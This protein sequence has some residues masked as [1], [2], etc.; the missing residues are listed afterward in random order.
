MH[1]PLSRIAALGALFALVTLAACGGNSGPAPAMFTLGGSVRGLSASG[2]VLANGSATA[3]VASGASTFSF[4]TVLTQ[5]MS[6]AVTVQT[7]PIGQVCSI[8]NGSGTTGTADVANVVVTCANQAY[9]LGGSVSGLSGSGLV[10]ANGADTLAVPA[11]ATTFTMPTQVATGSSYSITVQTQPAG[12]SCTVTGGTGTMAAAAASTVA[13]SC[14]DQP[15]TLG[16]TISGLST[17]GLVIAN[18]DDSV[19]PAANAT[20]FTLPTPVDYGSAYALSVEIQPTG[21]MCTFGSGNNVAASSGTMPAANVTNTQLVCSLQSYPLGG[22]VT[23][24]TGS[25]VLTD[26]TDTVTVD[27]SS[28]LIFTMPTALAYGSAYAL[29]VQTQPIGLTCTPGSNSSGTMPASAVSV[30]VTCAANTYTLGGTI[31]GLTST[32]LVLANGAGNTVSPASG[33]TLFSLPNGVA[34]GSTYD[35]TASTQPSGQTCAV[36]SASGT[37]PASSV[38]SVQVSCSNNTFTTAGAY[39][40]TVPAGVTSIQVSAIGG[41]GGGGGGCCSSTPTV[42]GSGALVSSTLAVQPGDVLTIYVGGGG[43]ATNEGSGGGGLTYVGD[44]PTNFV[45][46][47][48]GGGAGAGPGNDA[49]GG[50]AGAAGAS[51]GS[52]GGGGAG[53]N[54]NGGSAGTGNT[55]NGDTP[56]NAFTDIVTPGSGSGGIGGGCC[57][58]SAGGSGISS[59]IGNGGDGGEGFGAGGGGG[60][61]GGGGGGADGEMS[62]GSAGGGGGGSTG[63]AGTTYSV[64]PANG[65]GAGGAWTL[66]GN[67]GSVVITVIQ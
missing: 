52:A 49:N 16:G 29:A 12:E 8:A 61:Y 36:T 50:N 42:G 45:I 65:P 51:S 19:S 59:T 62:G 20:R 57:T 7:Q 21:L 22:S 27:S 26:G 55:Q 48:G 13:V 18:G 41:G 28:S 14:T 47:G 32:G 54:G 43:G 11:N 3:T 15:F 56:G 4:G 5:G 23:G 6:Y 33:A 35:V 39:T 10:L 46:A 53:S 24:L 38:S 1:S 2:L 44:G 64:A 58:G 30:T 67:D 34:F 9:S 63:P 37:M 31:S 60:G 25:V 17:S 66:S 40:W